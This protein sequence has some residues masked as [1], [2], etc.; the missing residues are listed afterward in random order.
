MGTQTLPI[1]D[2]HAFDCKTAKIYANYSKSKVEK[3]ENE[4]IA[5]L[6]HFASLKRVLLDT[7]SVFFLYTDLFEACKNLSIKKNFKDSHSE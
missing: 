2:F 5:N 6:G 1:F 3:W 4:N 7:F